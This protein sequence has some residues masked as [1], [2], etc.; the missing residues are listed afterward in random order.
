MNDNVPPSIA[1]RILVRGVIIGF[2]IAFA[3]RLGWA[4]GG[5]IIG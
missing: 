5:W 1:A 4:A 3:A 2:L